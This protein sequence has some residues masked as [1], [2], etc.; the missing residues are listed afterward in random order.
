MKEAVAAC[1][2]GAARETREPAC[3]GM[4]L[5]PVPLT[6]GHDWNKDASRALSCK[7]LGKRFHAHLTI[8][9]FSFD[10]EISQAEFH[11]L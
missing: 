6:D 8:S 9:I 1:E 11:F 5:C 4:C 2:H 10:F 7:R 3:V